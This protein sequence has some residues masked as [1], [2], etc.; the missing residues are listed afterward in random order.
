MTRQTSVQLT[1]A[2]ERQIDYLKER[3]YGTFTDI[4][5]LA[6]DRMYLQVMRNEYDGALPTPEELREDLSNT[7]ARHKMQ[8]AGWSLHQIVKF[9][10]TEYI[11]MSQEW[12]HPGRMTVDVINVTDFDNEFSRVFRLKKQPWATQEWAY[13]RY[14]EEGIGLLTVSD[15]KLHEYPNPFTAVL[16]V[17]VMPP[18]QEMIEETADMLDE[19]LQEYGPRQL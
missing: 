13:L 12:L 14:A 10:N 2:T 16:T 19:E 3:G 17:Q 9:G 15:G 7:Q 8:Q 6:I 5:R 1:E 18:T 4:A 11:L